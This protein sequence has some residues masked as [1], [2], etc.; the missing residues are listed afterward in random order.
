[1][2]TD[3]WRRLRSVA[4]WNGHAHH[5]TMGRAS[6][7]HTS[8]PGNRHCGEREHN[9][10]V[11]QRDRERGDIDQAAAQRRD[12]HLGGPLGHV[13]VAHALAWAP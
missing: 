7:G 4:L 2:D 3:P 6:S 8:Q 5:V 10:D 1:M 9:G 13:V 11:H 12:V